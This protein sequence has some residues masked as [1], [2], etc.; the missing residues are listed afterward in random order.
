MLGQGNTQLPHRL[1]RKLTSS[2]HLSS[3][4]SRGCVLLFW[5]KGAC[6]DSWTY[7]FVVP[8]QNQNWHWVK[9]VTE[10]ASPKVAH[11]LIMKKASINTFL[12]QWLQRSS[13][14][15]LPNHYLSAPRGLPELFTGVIS[16]LCC[17]WPM[18][19]FTHPSR[20]EQSPLEHTKPTLCQSGQAPAVQ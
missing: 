12:G 13:F 8:A 6:M 19:S 10:C 20:G 2:H 17:E 3:S 4:V 9:A 5:S 16:E 14:S 11:S 18:P 15:P 7:C 1:Q